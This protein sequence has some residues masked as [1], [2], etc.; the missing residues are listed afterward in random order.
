M[1]SIPQ[2]SLLS[3]GQTLHRDALPAAPQPGPPSL[4]SLAA[5]L[6]GSSGPDPPGHSGI[7]P[8]HIQKHREIVLCRSFGFVMHSTHVELF[9]TFLTAGTC[10]KVNVHKSKTWLR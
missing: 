8:P 3:W 6:H 5:A 4:E 9:F 1:L 2:D 7:V 10:V